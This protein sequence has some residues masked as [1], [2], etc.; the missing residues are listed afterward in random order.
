MAFPGY[1]TINTYKDMPRSMENSGFFTPKKSEIITSEVALVFGAH[2]VT[3]FTYWTPRKTSSNISYKAHLQKVTNFLAGL[4]W[5]T[6]WKMKINMDH[7]H[8]GLEDHV[9]F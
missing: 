3:W 2:L 7:N 9:P 4:Q 5:L 1:N 8:G 6:P